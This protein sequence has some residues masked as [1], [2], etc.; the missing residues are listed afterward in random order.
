MRPTLPPARPRLL[1]A[2][3]RAFVW[4]VVAAC[5]LLPVAW[6][7]VALLAE[8]SAWRALGPV[9]F[10][11]KLLGRTLLYNGCVAALATL[12]ALPVAAAIGRGRG[13]LATALTV[14]LPAAL[15]LPS[16]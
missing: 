15:L 3:P 5:G 7:V 10:H 6:M 2:A 14:V 8:P 16:I 4:A 9:G 12:L 1:R 13:V 11:A